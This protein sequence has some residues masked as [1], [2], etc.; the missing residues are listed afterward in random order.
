M[1]RRRLTMECFFSNSS[2][3]LLTAFT[4]LNHLHNRLRRRLLR[5]SRTTPLWPLL[6]PPFPIHFLNSSS[7]RMASFLLPIPG[8]MLT[9]TS[10]LFLMPLTVSFSK[11]LTP[12]PARFSPLHLH[13]AS[14]KVT[15]CRITH[16]LSTI[17]RGMVLGN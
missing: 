1:H 6:A 10:L 8:P 13:R 17:R 12:V 14:V 16:N 5:F 15:F 3:T 2:R 4:N 11:A 7:R 9:S